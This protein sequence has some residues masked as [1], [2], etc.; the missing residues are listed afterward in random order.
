MQV[1]LDGHRRWW[2]GSLAHALGEH[3][4]RGDPQVGPAFPALRALTGFCNTGCSWFDAIEPMLWPE[5]TAAEVEDPS[6]CGAVEL[7]RLAPLLE[8]ASAIGGFGPPP[9]RLGIAP[10]REDTDAWTGWVQGNVRALRDLGASDLAI[11]VVL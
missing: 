1:A 4:F 10:N 5:W 7:V 3:G 6:W 8:A 2:V 9:G 11:S